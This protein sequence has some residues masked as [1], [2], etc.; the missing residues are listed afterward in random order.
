MIILKLENC[1]VIILS[2]PREM[3]WKERGN[4]SKYFR[5][6]LVLK[7]TI[8]TFSLDTLI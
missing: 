8:Y 7:E 2:S 5:V 3:K 4:P 6:G 1:T